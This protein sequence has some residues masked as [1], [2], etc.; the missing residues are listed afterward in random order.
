MDQ[1]IVDDGHFSIIADMYQELRTTD[2]EP[3]EYIISKLPSLEN[4]DVIDLGCGTG[5]YDLLLLDDLSQNCSLT[6]V[7]ANEKMLSEFAENL[8]SQGYTKIRSICAP[9]EELSD[10]DM[11]K[12]DVV[13]SFNALHHFNLGKILSIVSSLLKE[14]GLAFL[15]SRTR[16]QNRRSIWGRY[17]PK[18]DYYESRLRSLTEIEQA[19]YETNGIEIKEIKFFQFY[20]YNSVSTLIEKAINRHYSTFSLY[21]SSEFKVALREFEERIEHKID[22]FESIEWIDRNVMYTIQRT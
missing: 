16:N 1:N 6:G 11:T 9:V 17:F 22:Q 18:F 10:K 5:R 3:I 12:Y 13:L 2:T 20:R 15:Y 21:D 8:K 14:K 4:L 19:I 7:D